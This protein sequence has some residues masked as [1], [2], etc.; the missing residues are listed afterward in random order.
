MFS[1]FLCVVEDVAKSK[2]YL[3]SMM[4]VASEINIQVG[5]ADSEVPKQSE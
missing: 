5:Q 4:P 3:L 2:S 1:L